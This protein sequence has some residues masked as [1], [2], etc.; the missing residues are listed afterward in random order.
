MPPVSAP[1]PAN[2]TQTTVGVTAIFMSLQF[3][4]FFLFQGMR[5]IIPLVL[6]LVLGLAED[7]VVTHWGLI[8]TAGLFA[9]FLTRMPMGVVADRFPRLRSLTLGTV[10]CVTALLGILLTQNILVIALA[11]GLLRAGIH[12]FP[13][14]TRGF[15]RET[16]PRK[17]GRLNGLVIFSGNLGTLVGPVVMALFLDISLQVLVGGTAVLLVAFNIVMV[18]IVPPKTTF[19]AMTV[20][21]QVLTSLREIW[22]IKTIVSLFITNGV[23]MG[24][25]TSVQVPYARYVFGL[26]PGLI[27][28]MVGAVQAFALGVVLVTGELTDRLGPRK[29]IVMGL[30][31]EGLAGGL[32]VLFPTNLATYVMIQMMLQGGSVII[33]TASITF[34]TLHVGKATFTTSFGAATSFFFLGSAVVPILAGE[35]YLVSPTSPFLVIFLTSIALTPVMFH[36]TRKAMVDQESNNSSPTQ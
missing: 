17:H 9:G 4:A 11:F 26:S 33:S 10:L 18:T 27:G 30:A 12:V 5:T 21:E 14:V 15:V 32:L 20:G 7:E 2:H 8:Y 24:F 31:T 19:P 34:F 6:E 16:D 35:M 28:L 25:F 36:L 22:K 23:L 1:D 3:V 13:L 29:L